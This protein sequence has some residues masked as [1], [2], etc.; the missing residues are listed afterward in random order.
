MRWFAIVLCL[1]IGCSEKRPPT[2]PVKPKPPV[3]EPPLPKTEPAKE[4]VKEPKPA[5]TPRTERD[6]FAKPKPENVPLQLKLLRFEKTAAHSGE[7]LFLLAYLDFENPG[8]ERITVQEMSYQ[9]VVDGLKLA[10]NKTD[11]VFSVRPGKRELTLTIQEG[12]DLE[13]LLAAID[14]APSK[15]RLVGT[16][17]L[18]VEGEAGSKTYKFS[19]WLKN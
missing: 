14:L 9:F 2:Q 13:K 15:I 19:E 10:E 1:S 17:R 4:P 18:R 8:K 7:K 16:M 5:P 6:P 11:T 12:G 3:E